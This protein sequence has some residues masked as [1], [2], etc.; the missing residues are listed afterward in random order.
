MVCFIYLSDN[1]KILAMTK[2][3][4]TYHNIAFGA[5]FSM[6]A[7]FG[8][9]HEVGAFIGGVAFQSD[10]V[11]HDFKTNAGNTGIGVGLVHYMNLLIVQNVTV[12]LQKLILTTTLK[13][14]L[15]ILQQYKI[16]T[17]W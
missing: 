16:R 3:L 13:F 4:N 10:F 6:N 7:Q 9:S 14:V 11:R 15:V 2:K 12:T 17:F 1:G 5:N 8:F